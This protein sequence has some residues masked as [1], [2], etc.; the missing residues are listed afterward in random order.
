M[1]TICLFYSPKALFC[2]CT[3]YA[4]KTTLKS[5]LF[6]R[7]YERA[8]FEELSRHCRSIRMHDVKRKYP[9][10]NWTSKAFTQVKTL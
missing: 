3:I 6:I 2:C 9:L 8:I 7:K 10:R 4:P 5:V 1:E